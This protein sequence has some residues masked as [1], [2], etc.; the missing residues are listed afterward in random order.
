MCLEGLAPAF[1][2]LTLSD[3]ATGHP[4]VGR[5]ITFTVGTTTVCTA[6][7]GSNGTATCHGPWP[8][9]LALLALHYTASFAGTPRPGTGQR[10]RTAH[11]D[12]LTHR[13][14]NRA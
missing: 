11:P 3:T 10:A 2:A 9:L 4:A 1:L 14:P 13:V 5:L 12:Q 6:T 8:V 7:T